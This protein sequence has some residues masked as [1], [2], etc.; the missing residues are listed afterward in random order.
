M[1]FS[2]KESLAYIAEN[3]K[4]I[5][6]PVFLMIAKR[7]ELK[8]SIIEAKSKLKAFES[9]LNKLE[10]TMDLVLKN[11]QDATHSCKKCGNLFKNFDGGDPNKDLCLKCLR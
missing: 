8:E 7:I 10:F 4:K 6:D 2:E 3:Y 1:R 9:D 11:Y 5:D